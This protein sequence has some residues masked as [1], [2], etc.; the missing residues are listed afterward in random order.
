MQ[1]TASRAGLNA[2]LSFKDILTTFLVLRV[3]VESFHGMRQRAFM[4]ADR[5]EQIADGRGRKANGEWHKRKAKSNCALPPPYENVSLLDIGND[6]TK[7]TFISLM[8]LTKM[9]NFGTLFH[10]RISGQVHFPI[11][12]D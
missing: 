4:P 7:G 5:R 1:V 9:L 3:L 12:N 8:A 2:L 10:V 11:A 6:S